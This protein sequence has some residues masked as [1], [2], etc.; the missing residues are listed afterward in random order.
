M[1][2]PI[3]AKALTAGLAAMIV[4]AAASAQEPTA[5]DL[6]ATPAA[7]ETPATPNPDEMADS[8][9]KQQKLE[10]TYTLTRTVDGKVVETT[11]KTVVY[12]KD[13][14][15]RETEAGLSPVERLKAELDD[16]SLTRSEAVA[17]TKLDFTIADKDRNNRVTADEDAGLVREWLNAGRVDAGAETA[18]PVALLEA[19]ED[20][21]TLDAAKAKFVSFS[22]TEPDLT[23]RGYTRFVVREFDAA[24]ADKNRVLEGAELAAFKA[25]LRGETSASQ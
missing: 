13:D 17:D 10:Q 20:A 11:Q 21:G 23:R 24:D 16:A 25:A 8:L 9:N 5:T 12:S 22:G 7:A 4:V 19:G 6:A 3:A 18:E 1:K 14:P 15:I 2:K